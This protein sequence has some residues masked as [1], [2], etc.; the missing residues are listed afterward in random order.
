MGVSQN[1]YHQ[2]IDF[3]KKIKKE[4]DRFSQKQQDEEKMLM[5]L[6]NSI[7]QLNLIKI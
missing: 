7:V 6:V 4:M 3:D 5:L 1:K 2:K